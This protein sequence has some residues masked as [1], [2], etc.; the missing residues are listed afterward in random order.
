[1]LTE[2]RIRPYDLPR[3]P[4]PPPEPPRAG[5]PGAEPDWLLRV[6]RLFDIVADRIG[7]G[8]Q[9]GWI[10][11]DVVFGL[12]LAALGAVT[13]CFLRHTRRNSHPN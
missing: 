8:R 9:Y 6:E 12:T 2:E 5:F 3:F 1:M 13:W 4:P 11:R 7:L 10:M